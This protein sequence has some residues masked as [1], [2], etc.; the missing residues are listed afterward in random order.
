MLV[1]E[2]LSALGLGRQDF[3]DEVSSKNTGNKMSGSFYTL[4]VLPLNITGQK[5]DKEI[6]HTGILFFPQSLS[7]KSSNFPTTNCKIEIEKY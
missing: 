6:L 3:N 5:E 1:P 7:V 4:C 2:N